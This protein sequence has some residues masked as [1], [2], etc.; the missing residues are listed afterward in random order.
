MIHL[1]CTC[2]CVCVSVRGRPGLDWGKRQEQSL[3]VSGRVGWQQAC[4]RV[5]F[6]GL[7]SIRYMC[8]SCVLNKGNYLYFRI[9]SISFQVSYGFSVWCVTIIIVYVIFAPISLDRCRNTVWWMKKWMMNI[10]KWKMNI[11]PC[12]NLLISSLRKLFTSFELIILNSLF[13]SLKNLSIR[14]LSEAV[15]NPL[16][17]YMVI[18]INLSSSV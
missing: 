18:S 14:D 7:K 10:E 1:H 15:T 2:E 17:T 11:E 9:H 6:W 8:N 3:E 12:F 5:G 4:V 16:F 13:K